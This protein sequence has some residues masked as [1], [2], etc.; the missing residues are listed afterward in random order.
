M[1]ISHCEDIASNKQINIIIILFVVVM[2]KIRGMELKLGRLQI[3]I[4]VQPMILISGADDPPVSQLVFT[5]MER[6]PITSP[7]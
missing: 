3:I 5:I 7:G 2:Q 6:A 1:P 4:A